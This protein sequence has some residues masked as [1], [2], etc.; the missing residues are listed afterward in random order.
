M[1]NY[2]YIVSSLPV[3]AQ[4][5][6]VS[7]GIDAQEILAQIR[8]QLS[9]GD[10]ETLSFLLKGLKGESLDA[11]FY[12]TAERSGNSFIRNFFAFDMD[13]RN[14]KAR[15]LNKALGQ[16]ESQDTIVLDEEGSHEFEEEAE[17]QSIL[18]GSD[19]LS[20]ERALDNLYWKKVEELTLFDYFDLN[21]VLGFVVRLH[22]VERWLKLDEKTGHE[23]FRKLVGE[24]SATF[25]GVNY[26]E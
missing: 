16:P 15:Y 6:A 13:L 22:T 1:N 7:G 19:I 20:R 8:E 21:A 4:S 9:E 24:V 17:V 26:T 18:S 25:K 12:W 10:C 5:M 2:T 3:I 14:T 23:M 11:S